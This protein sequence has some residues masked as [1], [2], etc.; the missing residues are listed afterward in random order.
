LIKINQGHNKGDTLIQSLFGLCYVS[1]WSL[2]KYMKKAPEPGLNLAITGTAKESWS[3]PL[4]SYHQ[5]IN[6][7]PAY[8]RI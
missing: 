2:F 7:L 3:R 1:V 4:P 5:I 6:H 8:F